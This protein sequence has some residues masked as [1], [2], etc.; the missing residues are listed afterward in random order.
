MLLPRGCTGVADAPESTLARR[1]RGLA[2][3]AS[4]TSDSDFERGS[5]GLG[6]ATVLVPPFPPDPAAV[7]SFAL[8]S[9]AASSA[10]SLSPCS[11]LSLSLSSSSPPSDGTSLP[12][13]TSP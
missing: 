9:P 5:A 6:F 12:S 1:V 8:V 13:A 4:D 2:V 11:S 7:E 10:A 3:R